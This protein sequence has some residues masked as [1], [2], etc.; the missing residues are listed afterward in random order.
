MTILNQFL[1]IYT[2]C[3]HLLFEKYI[4]SIFTTHGNLCL[5]P[6]STITTIGIQ[7]IY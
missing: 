6:N 3:I 1:I 2:K 4:D 5:L 7:N